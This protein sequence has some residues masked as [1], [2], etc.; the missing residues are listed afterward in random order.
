MIQFML[1]YIL[2]YLNYYIIVAENVKGIINLHSTIF[3]LLLCMMQE[4]YY[5]II[6]YILLYLNYYSAQVISVF[7]Y[8]YL[9]STIF[10]LLREPHK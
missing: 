10:K 3:K 4:I 8:L 2:L 9:H 1:I 7:K 6:I 5:Y